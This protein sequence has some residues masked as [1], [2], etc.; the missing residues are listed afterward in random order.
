MKIYYKK[1]K[2]R[3]VCLAYHEE[4]QSFLLIF[5]RLKKEGDEE[6]TNKKTTATTRIFKNKLV[7][8]TI[9]LTKQA[10]LMLYDNFNDVINKHN[11]K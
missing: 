2:N 7:V 9:R 1:T 6:N 4:S 10:G 5:K 8:T 3:R 11:I